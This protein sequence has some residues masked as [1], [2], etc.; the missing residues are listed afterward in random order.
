MFT[1]PS[2]QF[3][4]PMSTKR[5]TALDRP[6][7]SARRRAGRGPRFKFFRPDR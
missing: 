7:A 6:N 3:G 5:A 1:N 2:Y 4:L